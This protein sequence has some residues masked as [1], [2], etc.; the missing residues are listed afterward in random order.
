LLPVKVK[1]PQL[2]IFV[3]ILSQP[4]MLSTKKSASQCFV[5]I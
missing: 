5:R 1:I 4:A 2:G 3:H